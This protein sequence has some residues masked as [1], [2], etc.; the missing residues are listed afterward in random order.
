MAL[1][2]AAIRRNLQANRYK[3]LKDA[4][5]ENDRFIMGKVVNKIFEL[6]DPDKDRAAAM[7]E[8]SEENISRVLHGPFSREGQIYETTKSKGSTAKK[9]KAKKKKPRGW[10]IARY[11]GK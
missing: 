3:K 1:S 5:M 4:A 2:E 10:G 9:K 8:G 11:K 7:R 6:L